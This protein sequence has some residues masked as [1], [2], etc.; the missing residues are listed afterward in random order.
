MSDIAVLTGITGF[1]GGHLAVALLDAGYRVRGSLRTPAR[2]EATRAALAAAGADVSRLDFVTLDITRDEGWAEAMAGARFLVHAASPFVTT[3]PK[4]KQDLI[5]PAVG[6]VDRAVTAGLAAGVE[7]IVLTSSSVAIVSGRGRGGK[8]HLTADDW[9]NPDDGRMTAYGESKL[10]AERRAWELVAADPTRLT[11]I[12]PGFILGPLLDD[13]P[14]VSGA[15]IQ[16]FL[17][18]QIP[19]APD[20]WLLCVDVRDV[21]RVQV[22]ALMDPAV[23]GQRVPT[24][25]DDINIH[26]L[27]RLLA[28]ARPERAR[29]MPRFRAPD[30]AIRLFALFDGDTRAN[31]GE[32]GYRP[33]LDAAEARRL[34]GRAPITIDRSVADMAGSLIDRDL[35]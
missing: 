2:A 3:M 18:G 9:S 20:L 27:G 5:G 21:A 25:F 16:R 31:V 35:A 33:T 26:G 14:G 32:L 30:W 12:N 1:L 15:L 22:A 28:K 19:M 29:R 8:Q 7:R 34:L 6:G 17:R 24:A 13:D 4:D 10:L 11:T 23:G